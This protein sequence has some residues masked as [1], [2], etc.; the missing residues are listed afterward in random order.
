MT[1]RTVLRV[2]SVRS[3]QQQCYELLE[4]GRHDARR[5][6]M[7]MRTTREPGHVDKG[8]GGGREILGTAKVRTES[9]GWGVKALEA[10]QGHVVQYRECVREWTRGQAAGSEST[11][12]SSYLFNIK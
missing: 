3:G 9:Q 11:P 10:D 8:L 2:V 5:G 1:L 7:R 12:D 4:V 6:F